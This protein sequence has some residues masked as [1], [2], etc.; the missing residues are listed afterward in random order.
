MGW[1]F[2]LLFTMMPCVEQDFQH[3]SSPVNDAVLCLLISSHIFLLTV[4]SLHVFIYRLLL[5]V[6]VYMGVWVCV[7]VCVPL[8]FTV[9][10]FLTTVHILGAWET[11]P[12]VCQSHYSC[13]DVR[14]IFLVFGDFTAVVMWDHSKVHSHYQ[15]MCNN[16][17][18]YK[19]LHFISVI[20]KQTKKRINCF[21]YKYLLVLSWENIA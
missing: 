11:L 1:T 19:G 15:L 17:M 12:F 13:V 7:C 18:K 16:F 8:I 14:W 5:C 21:L 9:H 3:S 20:K 2:C 6:F 10:L 4:F